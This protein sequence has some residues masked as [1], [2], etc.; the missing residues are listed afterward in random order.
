MMLALICLNVCVL[1]WELTFLNFWNAS[2]DLPQYV[3]LTVMHCFVNQPTQ[4]SG[5]S[6]LLLPA[7]LCRLLLPFLF[8]SKLI[9]YLSL[10]SCCV[11]IRDLWNV[12]ISVDDWHHKSPV[13]ENHTVIWMLG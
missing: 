12:L 13:L 8:V 11:R 10:F 4:S 2:V 7:L 1:K 9:D 3:V 5:N 6:V